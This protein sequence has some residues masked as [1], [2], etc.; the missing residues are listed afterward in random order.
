MQ[1]VIFLEKDTTNKREV[2]S[3][4]CASYAL[5]L[6]AQ[7]KII[8]IFWGTFLVTCPYRLG[9][10]KKLGDEYLLF[11]PLP[12]RVRTAL[13]ARARSAAKTHQTEQNLNESTEIY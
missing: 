8:E 12:K 9:L 10:C 7:T 3:T 5:Y 4:F 6:F 1:S 13:S 2:L 11:G